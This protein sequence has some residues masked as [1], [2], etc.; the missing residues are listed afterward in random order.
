MGYRL[1]YAKKYDVLY[2]GGYFSHNTVIVNELFRDLAELVGGYVFYYEEEVGHSKTFEIGK[3]SFLNIIKYLKGE[4]LLEDK[5]LLYTEEDISY[6]KENIDKSL[7]ALDY[8]REKFAELLQDI[9]DNSAPE[10]DYI[11]LEWY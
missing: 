11:L 10:I 2:G 6:M 1:H 5:N 7:I 4:Y 3:G 9:Y 8:T